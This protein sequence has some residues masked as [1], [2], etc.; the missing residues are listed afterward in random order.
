MASLRICGGKAVKTLLPQHDQP[1]LR[2]RVVC[3]EKN[4]SGRTLVGLTVFLLFTDINSHLGGLS[5]INLR[6]V[7][8]WFS[9]FAFI[10]A[11]F[12]IFL[13]YLQVDF[14]ASKLLEWLLLA[15]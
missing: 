6:L 14:D 2:E 4:G 9:L 7:M 13:S 3:D 5:V 11:A 15:A 8:L 10:G 12:F 1:E